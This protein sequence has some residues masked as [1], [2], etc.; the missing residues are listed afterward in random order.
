MKKRRYLPVLSLC[1]MLMLAVLSGCGPKGSASASGSVSLPAAD[2]SEP[3]KIELVEP[4][5]ESEPDV[6]APAQP[7][8]PT[9]PDK[10]EP[11]PEQKPEKKPE[12]KPELDLN[13][14]PGFLNGTIQG[15]A[16]P[17]PIPETPLEVVGVGQYIGPY[18]ED[19]TD[20][21]VANVLALV[22]KNTDKKSLAEIAKLAFTLNGSEQAVFQITGLPGGEYV[23]VLEQERHA[24]DPKDELV[25]ADKMYGYRENNAFPKD[26]ME[27]YSAD[28]AITVK[29]LTGEALET[30]Y[31]RYKSKLV[32]QCYLGGI[33]YSCKVEDIPA[34]QEKTALTGHF[35]GSGSRIVMIE[36]IK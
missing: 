10:T 36:S 19:G 22:V 4:G 34:G 3:V 29:N 8:Q 32:P 16:L 12:Q 2:S 9:Q 13:S 26:Q 20:E 11:A 33:T 7:E 30:V 5:A 14:L 35:S 6:S 24:Y 1:M 15:M 23:L 27:I 25:F 17:F 18:V 31:I 28:G 21:P